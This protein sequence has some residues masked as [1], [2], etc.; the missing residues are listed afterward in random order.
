MKK[1]LDAPKIKQLPG[2][3]CGVASL[4]MIV[5]YHGLQISQEDLAQYFLE[6]DTIEEAGVSRHE[7]VMA[8]RELGFIAHPYNGLNLEKVIELIDRDLPIIAR[9]K[10]KSWGWGHF[11]VIKGYD[12]K[13]PL[14]YINNPDDLRRNKIDWQEFK[15]A[16][17]LSRRKWGTRN[18]GIVVRKR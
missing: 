15:Y 9:I 14:I 11:C 10:S 16:W 5:A 13:Q 12:D 2:G 4:N 8:A 17:D 6:P 1:V 7:I 18:Y 3:Y